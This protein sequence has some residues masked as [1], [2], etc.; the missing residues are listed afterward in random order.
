MYNIDSQGVRMSDRESERR[1]IGAITEEQ[2]LIL[3]KKTVFIA[4]CGGLGGYC[5]ELLFRLGIGG[6]KLCD[7]DVFEQSNL[8]RQLYC[9]TTTLGINKA[10]AIARYISKSAM[11]DI[12]SF[13]VRISDSNAYD[14]IRDCDLV[15]DALDNIETRFELERACAQRKIPLITGGVSHWYG[16]ISTVFPGDDSL[17]KIYGNMASQDE[18][19]V[20]AFTAC[21]I[22]S[23]QVAEA[24]RTLLGNPGLRNKLLAIDLY[25]FSTRIIPLA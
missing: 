20:L 17:R 14:L 7:C 2:Q 23:F 16:Q 12:K 5:A 10:V 1:N 13:A 22:A 21:N 9:N 19:P 24:V 18:P 4:G 8:N 15:I 11:S 25:D 3:R 6:L